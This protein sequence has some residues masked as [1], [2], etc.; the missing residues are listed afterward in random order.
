MPNQVILNTSKR[1]VPLQAALKQKPHDAGVLHRI[2]RL[3]ARQNMFPGAVSYMHQALGI[4]PDHPAFHRDI[5]Q[6]YYQMGRR[7]E[8]LFHLRRAVSLNPECAD[9]LRW[10]GVVLCSQKETDVAISIF[11]QAANLPH[12]RSLSLALLAKAH[13]D[14]GDFAASVRFAE[15]AVA[16]SGGSHQARVVLAMACSQVGDFER[17]LRHAREE[18]QAAP[19]RGLPLLASMLGK[20]NRY[21]EAVPVCRRLLRLKHEDAQTHFLLAWS[22]LMLG[23]YEN[24]WKEYEW[25][26]RR[27][28]GNLDQGKFRSRLTEPMWQGEDI[29]GKTVLVHGEQGFGDNIMF[30]RYVKCLLQLGAKVMLLVPKELVSLFREVPGISGCYSY[31]DLV[32]RW[33]FHVIV[34]SLPRLFSP[35]IKDIPNGGPY[36]PVRGRPRDWFQPRHAS[37]LNVGLIWAGTKLGPDDS[38]AIDIS[39]I[40]KL[41]HLRNVDF[42]SLQLGPKSGEIQPYISPHVFDASRRIHE[43]LDTASVLVRLDVLVTVDTG[44][45]HLAGAIGVKVFTMLPFAADFRWL[46]NDPKSVNYSSTPWYP[47]MRLFR[48]PTVGNWN[49]VVRAVAQ[50]LRLEA[51]KCKW[52]RKSSTSAHRNRAKTLD[53]GRF[54]SPVARAT[55]EGA[56][57]SCGQGN[58]DVPHP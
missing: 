42:Y 37:R 44:V 48:Q 40:S 53:Y 34:G 2:A 9:S 10:L 55:A 17:S 24:G 28:G 39:H 4:K 43:F 35:S 21:E 22:L 45:A 30:I 19:I 8:A 58:G 41:F 57:L 50:A 54:V 3:F 5:G 20:A 13:F 15:S 56:G 52:R 38:R 14:K 31:F 29:R 46:K 16:L 1:L 36:I 49:A 27:D 51:K 32:P 47:T 11:S 25:R 26:L 18:A 7:D 33:D 6:Y 12:H 23:D